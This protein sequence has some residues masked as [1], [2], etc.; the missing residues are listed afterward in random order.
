[1][2]IRALKV[3]LLYIPLLGIVNSRAQSVD[4]PAL[5]TVPIDAEQIILVTPEHCQ[6]LTPHIPD[7]SVN[8]KPGKDVLGRDVVPADINGGGNALGLGQNGYS[9]YMIH[10]ALKDANA[11]EKFGLTGSQEGRIIL[12]RVTVKDGDVLWNGNSLRQADKNRIYML[13]NA[14]RN[15]KKRPIVKR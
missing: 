8:Y 7:D 9:F 5:Q 15:G 6:L 2:M 1:M 11:T 10:D 14:E 3:L 12:G 4:V 13:C